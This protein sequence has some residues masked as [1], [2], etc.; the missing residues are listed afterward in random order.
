MLFDQ[1]IFFLTF[2]T[3]R[4]RARLSTLITTLHSIFVGKVGSTSGLL[5][6]NLICLSLL[7]QWSHGDEH[8]SNYGIVFEQMQDVQLASANWIHTWKIDIPEEIRIQTINDYDDRS[9]AASL[10]NVMSQIKTLR[11]RTQHHMNTIRKFFSTLYQ[12]HM[13]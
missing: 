4:D 3:Q 8:R 13:W 5:L 9:S 6:L 12:I 10:N 1:T 2:Y 7:I 11:Q